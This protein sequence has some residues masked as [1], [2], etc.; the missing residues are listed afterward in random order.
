M[1]GPRQARPAVLLPLLLVLLLLPALLASQGAGSSGGARQVV[2]GLDVYT[3]LYGLKPGIPAES[4]TV[5]HNGT[6]LVFNVTIHYLEAPGWAVRELRGWLRLHYLYL[7]APWWV[8]RLPPGWRVAWLPLDGFYD[9]LYNL[10]LRVL[11]SIGVHDWDDV[12]AV[13]GWV[14]NTSRVYIASG[15]RLLA[16][17]RGIAGWRLFTFYD[18]STVPAPHPYTRMPFSDTGVRVSPSTEPPIW[19]LGDPWGYVRGLVRDHVLYHLANGYVAEPWY[20]RRVNVRVVFLYWPD[21]ME[22]AYRLYS[23][24]NTTLLKA[25]LRTLD[26][27]IVYNVSKSIAEANATLRS[28]LSPARA[29]GWLVFDYDNVY[30]VFHGG[31]CRGVREACNFTFYWLITPE[32]AFMTYKWRLNFTG[33]DMGWAAAATYPGYG[34]RVPRSG[35]ERVVAHELGHA[36][37]LGHPFQYGDKTRWLMDYEYSV[38]SYCDNM[39]ALLPR[40]GLQAYPAWRLAVLHALALLG[41]EGNAALRSEALHLLSEGKAFGALEALLHPAPAGGHA[42]GGSTGGEWS[43]FIPGGSSA[44]LQGLGL[45]LLLVAL[46]LAILLGL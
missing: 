23:A 28:L 21:A 33:V 36:M 1:R 2:V 41:H 14:D 44:P 27:Y 26:P 35:M 17:L 10:T 9:Y 11:G 4:F 39:T 20:A 15:P 46:V 31:Y 43:H 5:T 19:R 25:M 6:G 29:G 8:D 22:R 24:F 37:G 18:L 34:L 38:M 3:V 42:A 30:Q 16:G 32:D 40:M 12:V 13:I 45:L 7:A